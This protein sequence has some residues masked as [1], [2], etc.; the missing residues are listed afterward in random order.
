MPTLRYLVHDTDAAVEFYTT[1]LG[2]TLAERWGEAFA[3]VSKDGLT[4]W[5]SGPQTSAAQPMP[6]G[7]ID[8]SGCPGAGTIPR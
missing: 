3:I 1:A 6:D 2:F 5:L 4:L 8:K 7:R